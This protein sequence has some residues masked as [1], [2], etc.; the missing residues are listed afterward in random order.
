MRDWC[1]GLLAAHRHLPPR[2]KDLVA[3]T[4]EPPERGVGL[5]NQT[6]RLEP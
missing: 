4:S 6:A 5:S 3:S 2:P 1:Q